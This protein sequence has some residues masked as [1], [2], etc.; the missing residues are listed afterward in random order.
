[1]TKTKFSV[2]KLLSSDT[3]ETGF[4][5]GYICLQSPGLHLFLGSLQNQAINNNDKPIILTTSTH[6]KVSLK[7][8]FLKLK[9]LKTI[10]VTSDRGDSTQSFNSP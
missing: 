10:S 1:M 8:S 2:I 7:Q 6:G 3:L 9:W 5:L 4:T